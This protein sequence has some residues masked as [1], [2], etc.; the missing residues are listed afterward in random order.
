MSGFTNPGA[1][2]QLSAIARFAAVALTPPAWHFLSRAEALTHAL[3]DLT[4]LRRNAYRS[5]TTDSREALGKA[6]ADLDKDLS[7]R[8]EE[9]LSRGP[10]PDD[11]PCETPDLVT[12]L[13]LNTWVLAGQILRPGDRASVPPGVASWLRDHGKAKQIKTQQNEAETWQK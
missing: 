1:A 12:V 3:R 4:S 13:T 5:G 6:L 9:I 10:L 2:G 11:L 7:D 8:V